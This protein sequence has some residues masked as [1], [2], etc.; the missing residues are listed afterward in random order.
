M[1]GQVIETRG[2]DDDYDGNVDFIVTLEIL[3]WP[4]CGESI[5]LLAKRETTTMRQQKF[6]KVKVF[7]FIQV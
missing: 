4:N 6:L 3:F 2:D 1:Q 7:R 5:V